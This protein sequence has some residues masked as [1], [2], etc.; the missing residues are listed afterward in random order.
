[1]LRPMW[2][3]YYGN[4]DAIIFVVDSQDVQ[5]ILLAREE[6]HKMLAEE[7]L[8]EAV[9]LVLANKQDIGEMSVQDVINKLDLPSMRGREWHC[10][11]T[12]ALTGEGLVEGLKWLSETLKKKV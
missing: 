12:K 2:K 8:K 10:Q 7:E 1:M 6:L 5:R 3:H 4:T 11:G 9:L